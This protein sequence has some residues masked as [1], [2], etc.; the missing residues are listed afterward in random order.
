[1]TSP[2]AHQMLDQILSEHPPSFALLFRPSSGADPQ[3][4]ESA[5]CRPEPEAEVLIGDVAEYT[6]LADLPVDDPAGPPVLAVVPF[7]Q[8]AE[9]G[10]DVVDDQA[11]LLRTPPAST[12]SPCAG[13]P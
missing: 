10:F 5:G 8:L 6:L 3:S 2:A 9:R 13:R 12:S 11:P 1:M 4:M 7:R